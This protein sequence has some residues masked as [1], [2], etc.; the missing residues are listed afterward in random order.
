MKGRG[1]FFNLGGGGTF[2]R[3]DLTSEVR[4]VKT[5]AMSVVSS[6]LYFVG[7]VEGLLPVSVVA[8]V[9]RNL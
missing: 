2:F 6:G 5:G 4:R 9:G 8:G 1:R 7:C 3:G